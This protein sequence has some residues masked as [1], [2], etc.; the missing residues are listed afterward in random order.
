MDREE[1]RNRLL[2]SG[3][4]NNFDKSSKLWQMAFDLY[5]KEKADNLKANCSVCF[6]KVK[7]W[8]M[9]V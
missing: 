3:Q 7:Q 9:K 4:I 8:L 1:I 2:T 5:N 6:K